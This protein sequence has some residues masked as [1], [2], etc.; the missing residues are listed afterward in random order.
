MTTADE[1]AAFIRAIC[2]NPVDDVPRLAFADWLQENAGTVPCPECPPDE[3]EEP[4]PADI[5]CDRCGGRRTIPDGRRERASFI[6]FGFD[7]EDGERPVSQVEYRRDADVWPC[8]DWPDSMHTLLGLPCRGILCRNDHDHRGWEWAWSRGFVSRVSCPLTAWL[9]H[10]P[11]VVAVHPVETVTL[12][13]AAVVSCGHDRKTKGTKTIYEIPQ[14][15]E[16]LVW[17][18]T[19]WGKRVA[20]FLPA[21]SAFGYQPLQDEYRMRVTL[22]NETLETFAVNWAR[23]EAG[24]PPLPPAT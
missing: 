7:E 22:V 12:A 2:I 4:H 19:E 5:V 3:G 8:R 11:K 9:E 15:A 21:G 10:G 13:G 18:P 1:R 14:S 6:R 16:Q 24:L 17:N 23:R 20:T